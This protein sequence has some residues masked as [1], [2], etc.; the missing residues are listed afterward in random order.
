MNK[1]LKNFLF[2]GLI[3]GG[4]GPIVV[5][6]VIFIISLFESVSLNATEMLIAVVSGYLLA[7]I[8]AGSTVF[9]QIEHWAVLKSVGVHFLTL[10]LTYS[11]CYLINSWIPF[12]PGVLLV[13]TL[14]FAVVYAVVYITVYTVVKKT[15]KQLN[16]QI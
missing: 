5:T 13:F 14:I 2:R 8:Q 9:N 15:A 7:F 3:F 16:N 12:E 4:F 10:Y 6:V 1:Y 11:T